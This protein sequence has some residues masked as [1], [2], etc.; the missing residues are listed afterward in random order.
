VSGDGAAEVVWPADA[1][2]GDVVEGGDGFDVL[3]HVGFE[4]D[5]G[6]CGDDAFE[7]ADAVLLACL[8]GDGS[9]HA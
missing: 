6:P 7:V 1:V 5:A 8:G 9:G 2:V 4:E 3:P